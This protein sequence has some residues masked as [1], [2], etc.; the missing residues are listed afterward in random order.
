[1]VSNRRY[2]ITRRTTSCRNKCSEQVPLM[3]EMAAGTAGAGVIRPELPILLWISH[4]LLMRGHPSWSAEKHQDEWQ[5]QEAKSGEY[6]PNRPD[7]FWLL[8]T[9][10]HKEL[11]PLS[12]C[13]NSNQVMGAEIYWRNS[14]VWQSPQ[15]NRWTRS[16]TVTWLLLLSD[17]NTITQGPTPSII[18][19]PALRSL[20]TRHWILDSHPQVWYDTEPRLEADSRVWRQ[21]NM[22]P[23][24]SMSLDNG[25]QWRPPLLSFSQKSSQ[26]HHPDHS[27]GWQLCSYLANV[28]IAG[29]AP[30][31][32]NTNYGLQSGGGLLK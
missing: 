23:G 26:P 16:A 18:I 20:I 14:S 9:S 2:F 5:R 27:L 22:S 17:T 31:K 25:S 4:I 7:A 29:P 19:R 11:C 8:F 21:T 24:W 1:M 3:L 10:F 28:S 15:R 12:G 13:I 6:R 30:E 32:G